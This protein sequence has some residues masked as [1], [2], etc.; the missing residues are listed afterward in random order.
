MAGIYLI[1][2][3]S[4]LF[5]N[6]VMVTIAQ[7]I[8]KDI[9]DEMFKGMQ[10]LPISYF[11]THSHGDIMSHYTNDTDTLRQ[12]MSQS[13][14]QTFSSLITIVSVFFAMLFTS[15]PLT[16]LVLVTIYLMIMLSGK[17]AGASSRYFVRQQDSI[18]VV[19]GY[20]EEMMHG[21][22]VVKVFCHEEA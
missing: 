11:D 9:R 5:Y 2:V 15:W 14:P 20:I 3:L 16:I 7:N 22:K 8:L 4:T 21:Q 1:G 18:G 6:R 17:I 10:H 12:M 19:N 13:I